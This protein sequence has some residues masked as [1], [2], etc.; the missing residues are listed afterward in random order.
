MADA[1]TSGDVDW[2]F[3]GE[4]SEILRLS[5]GQQKIGGKHG[6]TA[7]QVRGDEINPYT[8]PPNLKPGCA[9]RPAHPVEEVRR[10]AD[11]ADATHGDE[12]PSWFLSTLFANTP[13]L[14]EQVLIRV[15]PPGSVIAYMEHLLVHYDIC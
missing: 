13:V 15:C 8:G 6:A 11:N 2:V 3:A 1:L 12:Y 7:G 4:L 9:V 5:A 14:Q 10:I